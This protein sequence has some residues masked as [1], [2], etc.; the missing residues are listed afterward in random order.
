MIL[1]IWK[2]SEPNQTKPDLTWHAAGF[3]MAAVYDEVT[4]DWWTFIGGG[5][6]MNESSV[7]GKGRAL[8]QRERESFLLEVY[9]FVFIFKYPFSCCLIYSRTHTVKSYTDPV[10]R[11]VQFM[12]WGRALL[13]YDCMTLSLSY[14][15]HD[16][17]SVSSVCVHAA[18]WAWVKLVY[19]S[20]RQHA[21]GNDFLLK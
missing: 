16:P 20:P 8:S 13:L 2:Y 5:A 11:C 4:C 14:V 1:G 21:P 9:L 12:C 7:W 3:I 6:N 15:C 10:V 19:G 17:P 18:H